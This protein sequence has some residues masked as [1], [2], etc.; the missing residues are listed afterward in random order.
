M[1]TVQITSALSDSINLIDSPWFIIND[2]SIVGVYQSRNQARVAKK[3]EGIVGKIFSHEHVTLEIA[4]LSSDLP[5]ETISEKD[6]EE[7]A[8]AID[9]EEG[10]YETEGMK[11]QQ[12]VAEALAKD[13]FHNVTEA[14]HAEHRGEN[15]VTCVA[16]EAQKTS[17]KLD[18]TITARLEE[19]DEVLG[20][21]A[22]AFQMYKA[23]PTWMT[24]GQQD[25][26]TAKLYKAAKAGEKIE[27]WLN[28]RIFTLVNVA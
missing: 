8:A 5:D 1:Q 15:K 27:V 11:V 16:R 12:A 6:E 26:L 24:S 18:R 4:Y 20:T 10:R 23:N 28:G 21:W 7:L 3:E 19:N 17:M 22:N 13:D 14:Q 9:A 25:G 2:G